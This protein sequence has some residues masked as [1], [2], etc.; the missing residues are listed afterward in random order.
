MFNPFNFLEKVITW[1]TEG[2]STRTKMILVLV[3][4]L[5]IV[6]MG[7]VGYKINDYFENDPSSC[8]VCHVHD[9]ANKAWATSV[10]NSVGCHQCHHTTKEAQILQLYKF[11]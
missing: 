10:H 3:A 1:F 9:A 6:T 8:M 2:I 11:V 5:L 7:L 4:L